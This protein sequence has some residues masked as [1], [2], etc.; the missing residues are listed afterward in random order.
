MSF[1][2]ASLDREALELFRE[3]HSD[4]RTLQ[5][6]VRID[7]DAFVARFAADDFACDAQLARRV[8]QTA[9]AILERAALVWANLKEAASPH[10]R[11]TLFNNIPEA[12]LQYLSEI[13]DYQRLFGSLDYLSCSHAES[14]YGPAAYFVDLLRFVDTHVASN[15]ANRIPDSLQLHSRRPDL[16]A[17]ALDE[18]NTTGLIPYIDL[19]IDV[20]EALV[21]TRENPDAYAALVD[22]GH[23]FDLPF[24][25]PLEEIRAYL[26][27]MKT[28]LGAIYGA[29]ARPDAIQ[30][31]ERLGLSPAEFDLIAEANDDAGA[32]DIRYGGAADLANVAVFLQRTGL[33]RSDLNAL[34][35]QDLDAHEFNAGLSRLFF[36]NRADDGLGHLAI[37]QDPTRPLDPSYG[38]ER[39]LNLSP[40]KL[41]RIYR[42]VKLAR[43][44]DWSFDDLDWAL[45]SFGPSFEPEASLSFDG[46][47]D[48]V[49]IGNAPADLVG[50]TF[51]IEAWVNP[52]HAGIHPILA[53]GTSAG[54]KEHAIHFVLWIDSEGRLA[55]FDKPLFTADDKALEGK[56]GAD[57]RDAAD[58]LSYLRSQQTLPM[59]VYS[60]VAVSVRKGDVVFV[61]DGVATPAENPQ[62]LSFA[63]LG[64]DLEIGRDL[65]SCVFEG[66]I[67]DVRLW[68]TDRKPDEIARDRYRRLSGSEE[69]LAGYW[70]LAPSLSGRLHDHTP[71]ARHGIAGGDVLA[72][73]PAWIPYPL[74]LDPPPRSAGLHFD[75][76][77]QYLCA[78]SVDD[79][80]AFGALTIEASVHL[81]S[82]RDQ[83]LIAKGS[84]PSKQ[85]QFLLGL[86]ASGRL[87]FR[88]SALPGRVVAS[89]GVLAPGALRHVA[90][91]LVNKRISFW[92]DGQAA[93]ATELDATLSL[94]PRG[95][96]LFIGSDFSGAF[97]H[98]QIGEV[99]VWNR[100]VPSAT[101]R[102]HMHREV[103]PEEREGLVG[104]WRLD[105]IETAVLQGAPRRIARDHARGHDLV[106]GGFVED[107]SPEPVD[108]LTLP[109]AP[110]PARPGVTLAFDGMNDGVRLTATA[111]AAGSPPDRMTLS[112]WFRA[113][114]TRPIDPDGPRKQVLY[115]VGDEEGGLS[116][117]LTEGRLFV[118]AWCA[119]YGPRNVKETILA[120]NGVRSGVWH[121]LAVTND[122]SAAQKPVV[123]RAYLDGQPLDLESS[124]V[125]GSRLKADQ[126]GVPLD[127]T[128]SGTLGG[129]VAHAGMLR[130]AGAYVDSAPHLTHGFAGEIADL[131]VWRD[132]LSPDVIRTERFAPPAD[133]D[134][135][136]VYRLT[137]DEGGGTAFDVMTPP[138]S[139]CSP[140][141][142]AAAWSARNVSAATTDASAPLENAYLHYAPDAG[143]SAS[144]RWRNYVY[145]GRMRASDTDAGIGV[146]FLSR[147]PEGVDRLYALR[148][149]ADRPT[150][151]LIGFPTTD[152]SL[153]IDT[154]VAMTPDAW[155][156][157]WIETA[158]D[159]TDGPD[160]STRIRVWLWRD[161]DARPADPIVDVLD[162][163][164][165]RIDAG[166]VGVWGFGP[167]EKRFDDLQVIE[168]ATAG[169]DG[170]VHLLSESFETHEAGEPPSGWIGTG[171]RVLFGQPADLFQTVVLRDNQVLRT[172]SSQFN[173]HAH[174][175]GAGDFATWNAY[176]FSGRIWFGDADSGAGLTF[177]SQYPEADAYYRLRRI[178]E[179]KRFHLAS[180]PAGRI[181]EGEQSEI[182]IDTRPDTWYRF[183]IQAIHVPDHPRQ[184]DGHG[185]TVL[186]IRMWEDGTTEPDT[187]AIDAIDFSDP[188][189]HGTIGLWAGD[190]GEKMLDD[191]RVVALDPAAGTAGAELYASD[192]EAGAEDALPDGWVATA[193]NNSLRPAADLF[194]LHAFGRRVY[195]PIAPPAG[196]SL[197]THYL[198]AQG[199]DAGAWRNYVYTG[200][201]YV[202]DAASAIGVTFYSRYGAGED[203][204]YRLRRT[205]A[206]PAFYLDAHPHGLDLLSGDLA[207]AAVPTADDTWYRFQIQADTVEQG[208]GTATRI[209]V[210]VWPDGEAMP[211]EDQ[212]VAL[213]TSASHITAGTVGLWAGDTER[214]YF[215]D[216][217]VGQRYLDEAFAGYPAG[218]SPAGWQ[219]GGSDEATARIQ[220]NTL[221]QVGEVTGQHVLATDV[222]TRKDVVSIYKHPAIDSR[223]LDS[224]TYTGRLRFSDEAGG[225]GAAFFARSADHNDF[226]GL[227]RPAGA[228]ATF[229]LAAF[230]A[231][232]RFSV[233]VP[234]A[235][236]VHDSGIVGKPDTWYRFRIAV[237]FNPGE[238]PEGKVTVLARVWE[239]GQPEPAAF[240]MKAVDR[241]APLTGGSV[242]V[243][244]TGE[245]AKYFDDL[246]VDRL[247][248]LLDQSFEETPA[249]QKASAWVDTA[250]TPRFAPDATRFATAVSDENAPAWRRIADHPVWPM[251]HV[252]RF[253]G[254]QRYMAASGAG[255]VDADGF[256]VEAWVYPTEHRMNPILCQGES[257]SR[258]GGI[259]F[260]LSET[261]AP[262]CVHA[263]SGLTVTAAS[264]ALPTDR[265]THLAF[266]V[267]PAGVRFFIDGQP[268][269]PASA[270]TAE[271][272]TMLVQAVLNAGG[273][274]EVGRDMANRYFAGFV[275]EVRVWK[276]ARD[277]DAL[278]ASRYLPARRIAA[279]GGADLL[280][281]WTAPETGAPA[282]LLIP[283]RAGAPRALRLGGVAGARQP[284]PV[285]RPLF[286]ETGFWNPE[287][288]VLAFRSAED[289]LPVETGAPQTRQRR[290]IELWFNADDTARADRAQVLYREGSGE[291]GLAIYLFA[292]RLHA[293]GYAGVSWP[294]S[295]LATERI[296]SGQWHH[297]ALVLDG[298]GALKSGALHAYLDGKPMGRAAGR[299][300]DDYTPA[301]L[302][303]GAAAVG[304][305]H[306]DDIPTAAPWFSGRL[307]GLRIWET[308]R[309]ADEIFA[310]REALLDT[311]DDLALNLTGETFFG[312]LAATGRLEALGWRDASPLPDVAL[313][314]DS[315]GR[316]AR[317]ADAMDRHRLTVDRLAAIWGPIKSTGKAD[318]RTLFDRVYNADE[319]SERQPW[320]PYQPAIRWQVDGAGNHPEDLALRARLMGAL[321]LSDDELARLVAALSG[322]G[323]REVMLDGAYLTRLYRLTQTARAF[324]LD[325]QAIGRLLA[326]TGLTGVAGL[327]DVH[328]LSERSAWMKAAGI[329]IYLLDLLVHDIQSARA[330]FH[331]DDAGIRDLAD[332]LRQQAA[333]FLAT[334]DR[335]VSDSISQMESMV[336][337]RF[338]GGPNALAGVPV[339]PIAPAPLSGEGIVESTL[340]QARDLAGLEADPA[341]Q[342]LLNDLAGAAPWEGVVRPEE[343][344]AC[345]WS[346]RFAADLDASV[347]WAADARRRIVQAGVAAGKADAVLAKLQRHGVL[348][349]Q[350]Q[351]VHDAVAPGAL[352]EALRASDGLASPGNIGDNVV[353]A[354][355]RELGA[356]RAIQQSTFRRLVDGG[357]ANAA[358]VVQPEAAIDDDALR[359]LY[360][361]DAAPG[362]EARAGIRAVIERRRAIQQ[363]YGGALLQLRA[364]MEAALETEIAALFDTDSDQTRAVMAHLAAYM[365]P[366]V[367][368]STLL[369]VGAGALPS[370]IVGLPETGGAGYLYRLSKILQLARLFGMNAGEI[371]TLLTSP[372]RFGLAGEAAILRPAVA[373][374]ERLHT[375]RTVRDALGADRLLGFLE[376]GDSA[377][378]TTEALARR[379]A[380]VTGWD[381]RQVA[382]AMAYF[383]DAYDFR[384]ATGLQR[385][386]DAFHQAALTGSDIR[387]LIDL[388]LTDPADYAALRRQADATFD[389]L[390]ARYDETTWDKAFKPVRDA[391][392]VA[393]RD[394]LLSRV[395]RDI[396]EDI[397]SRRDADL[398][399]EYLLIDVQTGS[400]VNASRIQQAIA[401][402]QLYVQRC[403]MN[404]ERGVD[405]TSIPEEQWAWMKNYRVWEANRKVFLYPENYIE[406]ELRDTKTPF[407]AELEQELMQS[408]IDQAAVERAYVNYLDR[409]R[410]VA[411]LRIVGSYLHREPEPAGA[412]K[413]APSTAEE[414]LYLVGR[415][416]TDPTTFYYRERVTN[417]FG[418]RWLPWK[419]IDLP[420]NAEFATPVYAFGKLFLFWP[421]FVKL[422]KSVQRQLGAGIRTAYTVAQLNRTFSS[423]KTRSD[424]NALWKEI[425]ALKA[426]MDAIRFSV[427]G[428]IFIEVHLKPLYIQKLGEYAALSVEVSLQIGIRNALSAELSKEDMTKLTDKAWII[429][430]E[431]YLY[432]ETTKSRVEQSIDVYNATIKYTYFNLS[433]AWVHPQT[434]AALENELTVDEYRRPEWQRL[435]A[436]QTL[437]LTQSDSGE[438][439]AEADLLVAQIDADTDIQVQGPAFGM[440][441]LT[442]SFW[443]RIDAAGGGRWLGW[444]Y[445]FPP[446]VL[447][448]LPQDPDA[449]LPPETIDKIAAELI[450]QQPRAVTQDALSTPTV[451]AA[452]DDDALQIEAANA[453]TEIAGRAKAEKAVG[454]VLALLEAAR[455]QADRNDFAACGK[456]ASEASQAASGFERAADIKKQADALKQSADKAVASEKAAQAASAALE[457]ER[458]KPRPD[459]A[460]VAELVRLAVAA[461]DAAD[462]DAQDTRA[463]AE[464]TERAAQIAQIAERLKPRWEA[465]NAT[466]TVRMK[467]ASATLT[468]P[469]GYGAWRHIA[470][471]LEREGAG[472]KA[473]LY[474]ETPT[475]TARP[476]Q[477]T[478][479]APALT[480]SRNVVIGRRSALAASSSSLA[481][482]EVRIWNSVRDI[483]T[484]RADRSERRTGFEEG[485]FY[486]PL[487]LKP[488]GSSVELVS[489]LDPNELSFFLPRVTL[490]PRERIILMYGHGRTSTI[491]SLRNNLED[492]SFSLSLEAP[493]GIGKYDVLLS[494]EAGSSIASP[495]AI[496]H[497]GQTAGLQFRDYATGEPNAVVFAPPQTSASDLDR[498]RYLMRNLEERESSLMDVNNLPGWYIVDTGDEQFLAKAQIARPGSNARQVLTT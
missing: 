19:V 80:A 28:S 89:E 215:D 351:V 68:A 41:D 206:R 24:H 237:R 286:T 291:A 299:Q 171:D 427:W 228:G 179:K 93:G 243:W 49:T 111:Q 97:A 47:N 425:S 7:E 270:L 456:K 128:V 118:A 268:V 59:G 188:L 2:D 121:H 6:I 298:R 202:A 469:C 190:V 239:E 174:Y 273:D 43:K 63:P 152:A 437:Q 151:H 106:L 315:L 359:A 420:I 325:I 53:R 153:R 123:F 58:G 95:N 31:R 285:S 105:R 486:L 214:A 191:V 17:I 269:D 275:R 252:V 364:T 424:Q 452:Y 195:A 140:A 281:Y 360:E 402:V 48:V 1:I 344:A 57:L 276:G 204:Y 192:F 181:S 9:A 378:E 432:N 134:A 470:L 102:R 458:A 226:Y 498:Q 340:F 331:F 50:D 60:H 65:N 99:R 163:S 180:H 219:D 309:T 64:E 227:V 208:A 395:M 5:D 247:T 294:G 381:E 168:A 350:A 98:G 401:S 131:C 356:L 441:A 173:I 416:Q 231:S 81:E 157:F 369:A 72:M 250:S 69:H 44:L 396:P 200:R 38:S 261:G 277:A 319:A 193:S 304:P 21:R 449:D 303:G 403:L 358:G 419:K 166:S 33:S 468:A 439:K 119:D 310:G 35:Y 232:R 22:A 343:Q 418:E 317:A 494:R 159:P 466:I 490:V 114:D 253:D 408:D 481:M 266:A 387:Y 332:R 221:F 167:G 177:F 324:G 329:D 302:L 397:A 51:T 96:S 301:A 300:L 371:D 82:L 290:T 297:V 184:F 117:Y 460:R 189:T 255:F 91:T 433:G 127:F 445:T 178:K 39:I 83:V 32:L 288:R 379:I 86:D 11:Q 450:G 313:D 496:V 414:T 74:V 306:R 438:R 170:A 56:T 348:G 338:L 124:T 321:H 78:R 13:P 66:L 347:P 444:A 104:Y 225:A 357:I 3:R 322:D 320:S 495:K 405:P 293:G 367:V 143:A 45:R 271:A 415:T 212:I 447:D 307:L 15:P 132:T 259:W 491:K 305:W 326:L 133:S 54:Q 429:D 374:L 40:Q 29:F 448:L 62:R 289:G 316:L 205:P 245:G 162:V 238:R 4:L 30:I 476:V 14:V 203:R 251:R 169:A 489:I 107:Y 76:I 484:I 430:S 26:D 130:L 373:D 217:R 182:P 417:R 186:R 393:R 113:Q 258:Q 386:R 435:Y 125:T 474:A 242:G 488:I 296:R 398:L 156:R 280:A 46:I 361:P 327:D 139:P 79:Y 412:G 129:I 25:L 406:P 101:L 274:L 37:E 241:S 434:Y 497:L 36:I 295:W 164:N 339:T 23:P 263:R 254:V 292:G 392:A 473:T 337:V 487:N 388:A 384:R 155:Q 265:F 480:P 223:A 142:V 421:E 216:L 211:A 75:G 194:A 334:P 431:Y 355:G 246:V 462:R 103:P 73:Q 472:Y 136:L 264:G 446:A 375:Y 209:R 366:H 376:A 455:S 137:L 115:G 465:K 370:E 67:K 27:R 154:G 233:Q 201:M 311:A 363:T 52:A 410:E 453:V 262:A 257:A 158:D 61:I 383:G 187:F 218:A 16:R 138:A 236:K 482:A 148:R 492:Q 477:G 34:I 461:R 353:R 323:A 149:F 249:G 185:A 314:A 279:D 100:S 312:R 229:R 84:E 368:T 354:I 382:A 198:P 18:P 71:G 230:P 346:A 256:T 493:S 244:A 213:D 234:D 399:Y 422:K 207:L 464:Q 70:P 328:T 478:L 459:A 377:S 436:Q 196:D 345:T 141:G 90:V 109:G 210:R 126:K 413:T 267:S 471:T 454:D 150:F 112:F 335:F 248:P 197:H 409:F 342:A 483:A 282:H 287:R 224:Y 20:L 278:E 165:G 240:Q 475:E 380:G 330:S 365:P 55:L 272:E 362:P 235:D 318:G 220:A 122:Q 463:L 440:N 10:L 146:T 428:A 341:W 120:T 8:H 260:G 172:V 92:I 352:N 391:L 400:Q 443:A 333:D 308:A 87:I 426:Q 176:E 110:A 457:A 12:F 144:L 390:R 77:E 284:H 451:L 88:T 423:P 442:V 108:I 349:A 145:T 411:T 161:G 175:R 42:F 147:H 407:F 389:V 479:S 160:G 222:A 199:I 283:S 85:L 116:V 404:L 485:L 385:L 94:S 183:R 336:A 394:A 372:A 467:G 135:S